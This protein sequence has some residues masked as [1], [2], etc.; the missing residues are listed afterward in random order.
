MMI[1]DVFMGVFTPRMIAAGRGGGQ[2][3]K[4]PYSGSI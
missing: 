4:G 1:S 2:A 3:T